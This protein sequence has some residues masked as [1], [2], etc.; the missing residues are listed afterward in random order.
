MTDS[1]KDVLKLY[2]K[3]K[4]ENERLKDFIG[5]LANGLSET[6]EW[7]E[8]RVYME[9]VCGKDFLYWEHSNKFL[10][11]QRDKEECLCCS[12]GGMWHSEKEKVND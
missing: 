11:E 8:V 10:K 2:D 3:V 5:Y 1:L 6:Y 9:D 12:A 4:A 7:E